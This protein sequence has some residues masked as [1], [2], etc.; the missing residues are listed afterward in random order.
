MF[1][2]AVLLTTAQKVAFLLVFIAAGYLMRRSGKLNR[3]AGTVVSVVTTHIFATAYNIQSLPVNFTVE[4][5]GDNL[6]LIA[7]SAAFLV[8]VLVVANVLARFLG[9]NDIER[10]SMT[11]ILAFTN[12]GYFGLPVLQGVFGTEMVAQF[13]IFTLP[14]SFCLSS[15]GYALFSD[16][17]GF[18]WK[19]AF[20]SPLMISTMIGCF[21]GLT[22]LKFPAFVNDALAGAAAC[23]S[24]SSMVLAGIVLGGF[25]VRQLLCGIR[26]YLIGALR[27]VG[28]TLLF[29]IP[30]YLL[31]IRGIYMFLAL[32]LTSL[33]VGLNCIVYPESLGRDSSQNAKLCFVSVLMSLVTLPVIFALLPGIAGI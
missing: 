27:L 17:K 24:P 26:P 16:K 6:K 4:K 13:I 15:Y 11:Y 33:P 31:G 7:F 3:E 32:T 10:K 20:F 8:V 22:G 25:S 9:R 19:K 12:S 1:N 30:M 5:L 28:M 21:L 23:M 2:M 18:D 29:G 14:F